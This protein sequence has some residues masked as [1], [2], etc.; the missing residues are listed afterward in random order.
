[1]NSGL[2]VLLVL[3][4]IGIARGVIRYSRQQVIKFCRNFLSIIL[5]IMD[6]SSVYIP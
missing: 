6:V 5:S 2:A 4:T 3:E 1:M